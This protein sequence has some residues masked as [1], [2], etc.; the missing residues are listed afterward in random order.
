MTNIETDSVTYS[1]AELEKM[2][3]ETLNALRDSADVRIERK[4]AAYLRAANREAADDLTL[5]Q[6][7]D[8]VLHIRALA[9]I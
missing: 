3:V 8:M 1:Y 5:Q 2:N 4:R 9:G 7:I 6:R